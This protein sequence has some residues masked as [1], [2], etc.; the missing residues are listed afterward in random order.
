VNAPDLTRLAADLHEYLV[1]T[2]G[3]NW[4]LKTWEE[5]YSARLRTYGPEK[6]RIAIDGFRSM[7]WWMDNKS[8]D[9]PDCIFRS[10]KSFE[11]FLAAGMALPQHDRAVREREEKEAERTSRLSEIRERLE[12]TNAA[13]TDRMRRK[14]LPLR[15]E[16][17]DHSWNTFIAP[18]LFVD[19]THGMVI[20]FSENAEWVR[21]HYI[22]RIER[23]LGV[24]VKVTDKLP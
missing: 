16:I 5:K 7:K 17:N 4:R 8:Q 22:V 12:R 21:D 20:I 19:Y 10:D 13:Q 23:V 6:C 3:H 11:R 1:K 2:I 9:A 15:E 18:L 14:L 24:P